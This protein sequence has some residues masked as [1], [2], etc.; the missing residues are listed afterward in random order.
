MWE[1]GVPGNSVPCAQ[2]CC[3]PKT[4]LKKSQF[5]KKQVTFKKPENNLGIFQEKR[6][7]VWP[8]FF[9]NVS[10]P[11]WRSQ[12]KQLFVESS[13]QRRGSGGNWQGWGWRQAEI[14]S[15]FPAAKGATAPGRCWADLTCASFPTRSIGGEKAPPVPN[16]WTTLWMLWA[17]SE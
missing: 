10:I 17:V 14:N 7:T 15:L 9:F 1:E 6:C 8:E 12:E 5:K 2:F 3:E 13:P 11:C 16:G 4:A